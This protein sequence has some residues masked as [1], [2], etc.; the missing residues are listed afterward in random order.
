MLDESIPMKKTNQTKT[1]LECGTQINNQVFVHSSKNFRFALCRKHQEWFKGFGK[2]S[3]ESKSLYF[4]LKARGVP[5][6]LEKFDGHKTIDIVVSDAL[7]NIEVDGKHHS[8]KPSQAL[9]DLKRTCYS[10]KNGYLTLRIPNSLVKSHL[11]ETASLITEFLNESNG[12]YG[13]RGAA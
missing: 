12:R 3:P 1:C 7:V 2:A 11:D 4:A 5:A 13:A 6:E 10:F 9:T 8:F